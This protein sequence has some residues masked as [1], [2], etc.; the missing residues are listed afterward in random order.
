MLPQKALGQEIKP[1]SSIPELSH[2]VLL[3]GLQAHRLK[4]GPALPPSCETGAGRGICVH[5]SMSLPGSFDFFLTAPHKDR[6]QS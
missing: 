3:G 5:D 1:S 6:L 4:C 2:P